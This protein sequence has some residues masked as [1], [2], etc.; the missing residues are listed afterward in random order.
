MRHANI[1]TTLDF[2]ANIDDVVESAVL[3]PQRN[4]LRNSEPVQKPPADETADASPFR[5]GVNS[6]SAN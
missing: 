5:D 2:Y 6:S 1:Q 4:T 3:G